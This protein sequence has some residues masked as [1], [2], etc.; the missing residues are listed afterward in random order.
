MAVEFTPLEFSRAAPNIFPFSVK[1]LSRPPALQH[2]PADLVTMHIDVH[3]M[4]KILYDW[5]ELHC[6]ITGG[7]I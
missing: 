2:L 4:R 7:F 6:N 3:K 1:L 5:F